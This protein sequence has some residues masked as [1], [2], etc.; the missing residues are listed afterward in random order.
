MDE[1]RKLDALQAIAFRAQEMT[2]RVNRASQDQSELEDSLTNLRFEEAL[3]LLKYGH[4][5]TRTAWDGGI[6]FFTIPETIKIEDIP[7]STVP[8]YCRETIVGNMFVYPRLVKY[9]AKTIINYSPSTDDLL[10]SDWKI[11]ID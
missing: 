8:K 2:T 7:Q 9:Q 4:G 11:V 6:I 3:V 1:E 10:A 5:V